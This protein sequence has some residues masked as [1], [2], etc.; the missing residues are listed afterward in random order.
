MS[1]L[2]C[3]SQ[4]ESRNHLKHCW[5]ASKAR[6]LSSEAMRSG[7]SCMTVLSRTCLSE[8]CQLGTRWSMCLHSVALPSS[9][10]LEQASSTLKVL[11]MGSCFFFGVNVH[12]GQGNLLRQ[13]LEACIKINFTYVQAAGIKTYES[14]LLSTLVLRI[15]LLLH[16]MRIGRKH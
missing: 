15:H 14:L 4:R 9:L 7:L 13:T 2:L 8:L 5:R 3:K 10:H 1:L 12:Y 11:K 6:P 16:S